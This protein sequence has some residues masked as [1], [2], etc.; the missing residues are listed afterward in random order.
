VLREMLW[1]EVHN[2]GIPISDAD[3]PFAVNDAD[4][5]DADHAK[6]LCLRSDTS[7]TT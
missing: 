3:I 2:L 7:I 6:H 1:A 4:G 5:V